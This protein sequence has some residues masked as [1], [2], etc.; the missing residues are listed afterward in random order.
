MHD[1]NRTRRSVLL[2]FGLVFNPPAFDPTT[3]PEPT[4]QVLRIVEPAPAPAHE[5]AEPEPAEPESIELAVEPPPPTLEPEPALPPSL[6]MVDSKRPAAG[7]G[8]IALG[9]M[10]LVASAGLV[11]TAMAGPGWLDLGHREAA[12]AGGLSLPLAMSGVAII[13]AGN[14]STRRF[15][16]WSS[17]NELSPPKS[18]NGLIVIGTFA[19]LGFAGTAAYATQLALT[20]P[21]QRG[22][23]APTAIAGS[24]TVVGMVLLTA[25][26]LRRSKFASWQQHAYAL[27]GAMALEHGGGVSVSGRF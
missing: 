18:G 23:W 22:N 25:G 6:R 26:M 19:T 11:M 9:S 3:A 10:G 4:E 8:L 2:G 16:D 14:K 12:I 24:A 20:Q 5:P 27:P 13:I 21:T 1:L 15:K 17:R 7:T